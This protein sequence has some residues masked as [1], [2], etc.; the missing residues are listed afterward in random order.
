MAKTKF[1]KISDDLSEGLEQTVNKAKNFAGNLVLEAIPLKN[2]EL[3]PDNPREMILTLDDVFLRLD[4]TDPHYNL[5]TVELENLKALAL[6]IK[7]EGLINP[8][9]VYRYGN[10][11]RLIA[12]ERRTF[13]S[14]I[15]G[16]EFIQAKI[17]DKKPEKLEL[18]LLQWAE[19]IERKD[20]SLW[21]RLRNIEKIFNAYKTKSEQDQKP[22]PTLL[23]ELIGCSLPHAMNYCS[24][25]DS[26]EELKQLVQSGKIKNLEK[27]ALISKIIDKDL[28]AQAINSCIKGATLSQLKIIADLDKKS[29][30][31]ISNDMKHTSSR[32]RQANQVN[33]GTTKNIKAVRFILSCVLANEKY[34]SLALYIQNL[35]WDDYGAINK[36]FQQIL[37]NI[38]KGE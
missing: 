14:I 28:K 27:A 22:L 23:S 29:S 20:L 36:A 6:S 9:L 7:R 5:K 2:I 15:A 35:N 13:A 38:E 8:I 10:V 21:E 37:K 11:F 17:R 32:G 12:G 25:L 1:F 34:K 31:P 16:E 19:N 30:R 4:K 3:D 24:V 26:D 18:S 33:L